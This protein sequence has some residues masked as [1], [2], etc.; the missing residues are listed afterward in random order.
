MVAVPTL[1]VLQQEQV[2]YQGAGLAALPQVQTLLETSNKAVT[3]ESDH[4]GE[5]FLRGQ[6]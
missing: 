1:I 3:G 4:D 6:R 5:S 2:L